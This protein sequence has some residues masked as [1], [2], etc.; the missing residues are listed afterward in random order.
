MGRGSGRKKKK[1]KISERNENTD[2]DFVK[3]KKIAPH[4]A[5]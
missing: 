2:G 5:E 3:K 4:P 1:K